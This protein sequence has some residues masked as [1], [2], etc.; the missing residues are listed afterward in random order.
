L[1]LLVVEFVCVLLP[2]TRYEWDRLTISPRWASKHHRNRDLHHRRHQPSTGTT[3]GAVGREG[4]DDGGGDDGEVIVELYLHVEAAD[5]N[6]TTNGNTSFRHAT[7][8]S[9]GRA[10][11]TGKDDGNSNRDDDEGAPLNGTN[12]DDTN[13]NKNSVPTIEYGSGSNSD[14]TRLPTTSGRSL[15]SSEQ[16]G[17]GQGFSGL[18]DSPAESVNLAG[19]PRG[20]YFAL[21]QRKLTRRLE[22]EF[23]RWQ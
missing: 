17:V 7:R 3:A 5:S 21:V 15:C 1:S 11:R 22:E 10:G 18:F 14:E 9:N 6:A 19:Q 23:G 2:P 13:D 16:L 8:V 20:S 12:K 4:N